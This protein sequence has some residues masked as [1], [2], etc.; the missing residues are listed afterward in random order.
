MRLIIILL[1]VVI[2]GTACKSR[3]KVVM[4][5]PRQFDSLFLGEVKNEKDSL[6]RKNWEY[7]SGRLAVNYITEDNELSGNIS[8]RMRKD[9]II[10][11]SVSAS[12]GIQVLK[13]IITKDS[14]HILDLYEKKYSKYGIQQLSGTFGAEIGLRELQ[15]LLIGN[16]VFDTLVYR[17]DSASK[18]WFAANPPLSNVHF[19]ND[20]TAPDSIYLTQKGSMNQLKTIYTGNKSAGAFAVAEKMIATAFTDSK[21][22]RLEIEFTTASD[23]FIPS[24]PF[25]VPENYERE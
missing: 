16:P 3:K 4:E 10:W 25:S 5:Q 18:A 12:I 23:A 13:G 1:S 22:V 21:T 8:L 2:A 9:S 14:I 11:F 7:F 24:Y 17:Q 15:N 19:C 20:F 6:L